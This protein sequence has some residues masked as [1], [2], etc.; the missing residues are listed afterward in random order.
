MLGRLHS[1]ETK[2]KLI[3]IQSNR[4][5]SPT[6]GNSVQVKDILTGEIAIYDSLRN[7][8]K[9]LNSNH[10]TVSN[11]LDNGKLFRNRYIITSVVS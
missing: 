8:G 11:N 5:K 2:E 10:V 6:K 4:A 7:A 3:N 9:S 1:D